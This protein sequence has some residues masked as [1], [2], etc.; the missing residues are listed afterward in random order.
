VIVSDATGV[1]INKRISN[2]FGNP[3]PI[4]SHPFSNTLCTSVTFTGWQLRVGK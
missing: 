3:H 1:I 2:I 4:L